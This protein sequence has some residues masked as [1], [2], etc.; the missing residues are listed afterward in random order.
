MSAPTGAVNSESRG[1]LP[2][3]EQP[4]VPSWRL[5]ATLG[6]AGALAG[7]LIVLAYGWTL[8]RIEAHRAGVLRG[9]IEEVLRQPERAD[10]LFLYQ[11]ALTATL[12][13]GVSGAKLER[14]YRGYRG[15]EAIGYA[16][17]ASE[18]GFA[19]QIGVIFGYDADARELLGMKVLS[20]KE[21]PG[22]GDKIEK[23]AFTG[24]F[25]KRVMPLVGVKAAPPAS[26]RSAI[27]M[28]TGA[29]ISS[30]TIIK[31]INASVARWQPLLV[32]Y[33]SGADGRGRK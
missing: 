16:L 19:D 25:A 18:P 20:S 23:P 9:A 24:Q 8:P 31:E 2:V 27:V 14:V 11:G 4:Q 10:T 32:A 21:T 26:D 33:Q 15:G 13:A 22:L 28:I 6:G 30:R 17:T 12:P 3:L 1:P 7:L 29:T 5:L